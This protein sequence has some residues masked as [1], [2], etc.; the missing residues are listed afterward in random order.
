MSFDGERAMEFLRKIAFT[1]CAGTPEE[2]KAAGII[3]DELRSFG[4]KPEVEEFDLFAYAND[5]AWVEILEPY[6]AR[7]EG[8]ALG[9]SGTTPAEGLEASIKYVETGQPEFLH[10]I[11]GTIILASSGGGFKALE[12][13]KKEGAVGRIFIA[14]AGRDTPNISM[15]RCLR[16]RLGTLPTAYVKYEHALEMITSGASKVRLFVAQDEFWSKSRN[17]IVEIPGTHEPEEIILVG[18]HFDSVYRNQGAHDNA[19]GSATI[20]EMARYF[21][22]NP[23]R[24]TLRFVWFGGEEMGLMGSWAHVETRSD[25]VGQYIFMVNVDVAGGIIGSNSASV[26]GP[27]KLVN[28]L[29]ILGKEFGPGLNARQS[30]YSGDCIPMGHKGVPS[31]TFARGGGG[32]SFIHAP[33]D[34]IEHIDGDHLA[35]LG[36][37]ALEFTRR[38]VNAGKFPFEKEIPEK[39]KKDI[40]EYMERGGRLTE[41]KENRE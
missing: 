12:K 10:D 11:S 39:I 22:Q 18:A 30:I 16:D 36:D 3:C 19:A 34:T 6:Q 21:S 15:N 24:R 41:E 8:S 9:L 5:Q 32:T 35:M 26:M 38:I 17:V 28:Y 14:S 40:R 37:M 23:P 29:D 4:L 31:V 7:Y 27:E 20:M 13:A 25:D 33:G 1:R 2:E